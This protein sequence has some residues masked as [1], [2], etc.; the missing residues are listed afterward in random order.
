MAVYRHSVLREPHARSACHEARSRTVADCGHVR[1]ACCRQFPSTI[2]PILGVIPAV[3]ITTIVTIFVD[4]LRHKPQE[5]GL[6][7]RPVR[8]DAL[9]RMAALSITTLKIHDARDNSFP[10]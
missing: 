10:I 6:I 5:G 4:D 3:P 2:H 9:I 1:H 8:T 7:F